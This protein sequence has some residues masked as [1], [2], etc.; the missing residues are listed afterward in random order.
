MERTVD[1]FEVCKISAELR[2]PLLVQRL[3]ESWCCIGG[4]L[5]GVA[6]GE[7]QDLAPHAREESSELDTPAC[8]NTNTAHGRVCRVIIAVT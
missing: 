8:M 1:Q 3:D 7:G 6:E 2:E 4:P 5:D